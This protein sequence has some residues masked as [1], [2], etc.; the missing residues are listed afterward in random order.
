MDI[1]GNA[2]KGNIDERGVG[3]REVAEPVS[4]KGEQPQ[5][6][7]IAA[8]VRAACTSVWCRAVTGVRSLMSR[9]SSLKG[10]AASERGQGTTEYAILV[11]VLVVIAILAITLFK[12]KLEELWEAI[13]SGIQGL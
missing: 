4:A 8:N 7:G 1:A 2:G 9:L 11:G 6:R 5:A 3:R 12:P 10:T 13:A